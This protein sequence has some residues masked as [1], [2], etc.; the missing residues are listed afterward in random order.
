MRSQGCAQ[1]TASAAA[2]RAVLSSHSFRATFAAKQAMNGRAERR[3]RS[4]GVVTF[5]P[6]SVRATASRQPATIF[7]RIAGAKLGRKARSRP[8][9]GGEFGERRI[10]PGLQ[11]GEIGGLERRRLLD[12]R[13][14]PAGPECRR[15]LHPSVRR[16]QA[17]VD[18]ST[19]RP[20]R[21]EQ[22]GV[23]PPRSGRASSSRRF[24]A[25]GAISWAVA[26]VRP[27]ARPAVGS[28]RARR[29]RRTPEPDRPIAP[30]RR[31]RR[32]RPPLAGADHASPSRSIAPPPGDEIELRGVRR[33]P[34]IR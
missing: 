33:L 23:E 17:A 26:R 31:A 34:S 12:T 3:L 5:A 10:E 30:D 32:A 11:S 28:N 21:S 29:D 27:K 9:A 6:L 15:G 14:R 18:A 22:I 13:R 7:A 1:R 24:R 4:A 25:R 16:R 19:V 8:P 2:R 20:P